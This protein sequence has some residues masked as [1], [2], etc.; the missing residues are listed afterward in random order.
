[1]K[2]LMS[3]GATGLLALGLVGVAAQPSA[4]QRGVFRREPQAKMQQTIHHLQEARRDLQQAS[5]D[6][7][8]HRARA[9]RLINQAIQEVRA[10]ARYDARR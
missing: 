2:T 6:K 4:A 1:V 7:G 3:L 10:G 8:G 5:R 9:L